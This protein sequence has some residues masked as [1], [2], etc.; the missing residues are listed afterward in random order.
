MSGVILRSRALELFF[1]RSTGARTRPAGDYVYDIRVKACS[2]TST[3]SVQAYLCSHASCNGTVGE[4]V[5]ATLVLSSRE[6]GG[7]TRT[8]ISSGFNPVA[9]RLSEVDDSW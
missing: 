9:I 7:W 1:C 8:E 3:G 2:G 6:E 4:E 5:E